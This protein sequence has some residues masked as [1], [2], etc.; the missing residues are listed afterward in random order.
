M[1]WFDLRDQF[2]MDGN[3][4]NLVN[5]DHEDARWLVSLGNPTAELLLNI[6]V[7]TQ[8][9]MRTVNQCKYVLGEH[10]AWARAYRAT[11]VPIAINALCLV[12]R[13]LGIIRTLIPKKLWKHGYLWIKE[14]QQ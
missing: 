10:C 7:A 13:R 11:I 8:D 2:L 1:N 5:C 4:A 9:D 3:V 6:K 12:A 14:E